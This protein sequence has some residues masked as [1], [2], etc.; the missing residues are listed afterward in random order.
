MACAYCGL[1]LWAWRP[2][3]DCRRLH[4]RSSPDCPFASRVPLDPRGILG[5]G[6]EALKKAAAAAGLVLGPQSSLS[7]APFAAASRSDEAPGPASRGPGGVGA[8]G[9]VGV[10]PGPG[11]ADPPP[12]PPA[13]TAEEVVALLWA[14]DAYHDVRLGGRGLFALS[15]AEVLAACEERGLELGPHPGAGGPWGWRTGVGGGGGGGDCGLRGVEA[16]RELLG[17]H[18]RRFGE[19]AVRC[20][21]P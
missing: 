1:H 18:V 5:M 14:R 16:A 13:C 4:R 9:R 8:A 6:D 19:G 11:G 10:G 7:P 21:S 20:C 12:R 17:E 3:D 15:A 2:D